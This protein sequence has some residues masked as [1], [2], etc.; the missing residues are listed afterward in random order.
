MDSTVCVS[1]LEKFC[2]LNISVRSQEL[3]TYYRLNGAINI[4]KTDVLLKEQRFFSKE[5]SYAYMMRQKNSIDIVTETDFSL[6]EILI[7][8]NKH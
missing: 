3:E 1:T 6:A 8:K 2:F 7:N 4:I 5:K